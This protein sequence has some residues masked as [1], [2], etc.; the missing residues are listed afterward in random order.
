VAAIYDY[1]KDPKGDWI[2]SFSLL[3]IN[4]D[5]HPIMGQFHPANDEKRSIAVIEPESFDDWVCATTEEATTYFAPVS[6]KAFPTA[7]APK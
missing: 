5:A 7:P 2:P 3:T 1:W 6:S 4:A